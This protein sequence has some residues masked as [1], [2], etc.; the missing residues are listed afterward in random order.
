MSVD[1][2]EPIDIIVVAFL[3]DL[4]ILLRDLEIKLNQDLS[5]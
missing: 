4:A 2:L 5:N 3:V 1:L